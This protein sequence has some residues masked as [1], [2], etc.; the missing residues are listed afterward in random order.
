MHSTGVIVPDVP[1]FFTSYRSGVMA[2][3][4]SLFFKPEVYMAMFEKITTA[5]ILMP[6]GCDCGVGF[7]RFLAFC[8]CGAGSCTWIIPCLFMVRGVSVDLERDST[9]HVVVNFIL[10]LACSINFPLLRPPLPLSRAPG[11]CTPFFLP[12]WFCVCLSGGVLACVRT[13]E[14]VRA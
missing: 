7:P 1:S 5:L 13:H 4:F 6:V 11:P 12:P 10:C 9:I 8:L 2:T 14:R 3:L